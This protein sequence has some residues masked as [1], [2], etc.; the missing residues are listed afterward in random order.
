MFEIKVAGS[1]GNEYTVKQGRDG[2][3][4]CSCPAW[5]FQRKPA[6]QRTCKHVRRV[7]DQLAMQVARAR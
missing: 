7:A 1:N 6:A 4:Y 2:V 3:V 5:K